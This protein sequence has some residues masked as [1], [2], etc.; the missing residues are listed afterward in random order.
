[1]HRSHLITRRCVLNL[2][3]LV[4]LHN[5]WN[6]REIVPNYQPTLQFTRWSPSSMIMLALSRNLLPIRPR[7]LLI[8]DFRF[9]LC[10]ELVPVGRTS[11]VFPVVLWKLPIHRLTGGVCAC[12][13]GVVR[14]CEVPK[15]TVFQHPHG[16]RCGIVQVFKGWKVE[17]IWP[18]IES[19]TLKCRA[20]GSDC[21]WAR[22]RTPSSTDTFRD[23][24]CSFRLLLLFRWCEPQHLTNID[25]TRRVSRVCLIRCCNWGKFN[26]HRRE[27]EEIFFSFSVLACVSAF[28]SILKN[29]EEAILAASKQKSWCDSVGELNLLSSKEEAAV[30]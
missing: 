17:E 22:V 12:V 11:R 21:E 4:D 23:F 9:I 19:L 24:F 16:G 25:E 26:T 27:R 20:N 28:W 6:S 14:W 1:M 8:Q 5:P 7:T 10:R 15:I 18:W 29:R 30:V 13:C 3:Y 2:F